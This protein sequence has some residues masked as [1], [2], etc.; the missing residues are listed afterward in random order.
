MKFRIALIAGVACYV[1]LF[2]TCLGATGLIGSLSIPHSIASDRKAPVMVCNG[3]VS[4]IRGVGAGW[5][6]H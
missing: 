6:R 4:I 3:M 5:R 1:M 2:A